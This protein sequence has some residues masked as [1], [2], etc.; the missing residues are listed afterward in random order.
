MA[1]ALSGVCVGAAAETT[2]DAGKLLF[3][4]TAVPACAVCHTLKHAG[5][6]GAIG[7]ILDELKPDETRVE[8]AIR[9]GVGVMPSYRDSLSEAQIKL[10]SAYVAKAAQ[11]EP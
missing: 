5:A 11:G 4:Q 9:N 8:K 6:T 10:L 7:P 1:L 3:N 2:L